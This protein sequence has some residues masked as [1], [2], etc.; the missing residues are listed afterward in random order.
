MRD[1]LRKGRIN[2]VFGDIALGTRIVV[3]VVSLQQSTLH[4]HLVRRL[5]A[6]EDY[7]ADTAHG[8]AVGGKH[9]ENALVMKDV[10]G[11]DRLRTDAALGEGDVL[12][13]AGREMV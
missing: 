3:A 9:R 11:R 6:A 5:P 12:W 10:F 13:N 2:R 4:L 1:A 7:L 8:L